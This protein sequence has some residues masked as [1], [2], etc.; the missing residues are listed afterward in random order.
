MTP[1]PKQWQIWRF[2]GAKWV[3]R[4]WIPDWKMWECREV[5]GRRRFYV[6][7]EFLEGAMHVE[8][9]RDMGEPKLIDDMGDA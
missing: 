2:E 5:N 7:P 4:R 8:F 6:T 3:L 1:P 9:V